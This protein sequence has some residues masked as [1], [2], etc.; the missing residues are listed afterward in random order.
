MSAI[1]D[2]IGREIRIHVAIPPWNSMSRW[3]KA[4]GRAAVPSGAST[5]PRGDRI[6]RRRQVTLFGQGRFQ[7]G[8]NVN[9]DIFDALSGFD[10][11]DQARS[12]RR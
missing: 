3:K 1:V 10:A 7:G 8:R 6:A 12:T 11:E 2:I 4:S 5:G 9:R